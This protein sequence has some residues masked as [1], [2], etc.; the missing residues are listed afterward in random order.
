M[1]NI[2]SFIKFIAENQGYSMNTIEAYKYDLHEFARWMQTEKTGARWSTI[3]AQDIDEYVSFKVERSA[4]PS[5]IKRKIAAIRSLY[6]WFRRQG[7]LKENP[8]RY[9]STPKLAKRDPHTVELEAI[10]ATIEDQEIEA[11]T[12][13]QI[14]ILFETGLRISE[15][16]AMRWEDIDINN[17]QIHVTGKGQKERTVMY[18]D[19]TAQMLVPVTSQLTGIIFNESVEQASRKIHFA[20]KKHSAQK[21]LSPHILRHTM[22]TE[23]ARNGAS[24]YAIAQILGHES[25]KTTEVYAHRCQRAAM[26]Q[27]QEYAAL[28]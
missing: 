25:I 1:S 11:R 21:Y 5:T 17:R 3:T 12:R 7:L 26:Q 19:R 28:L 23:M 9:T 22:A 8:A 27:Y 6:T 18:G 16:M 10:K 4:S 24:L 15:L 13:F 14:A 2:E 20:L